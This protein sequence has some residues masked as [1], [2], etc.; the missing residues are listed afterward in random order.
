[1]AGDRR[2]TS[3]SENEGEVCLEE[4]VERLRR[5]GM[6]GVEISRTMGV[7]QAWVEA[8]LSDWGE[9]TSAEGDPAGDRG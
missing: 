9:E 3:V 6:S 7:D 2:R 5:S 4:V 8:L 1:M